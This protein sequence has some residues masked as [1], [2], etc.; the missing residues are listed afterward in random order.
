MTAPAPSASRCTA[1]NSSNSPL[2]SG[3]MEKW[4][5]EGEGRW[6]TVYANAG[7]AYAVIAG[8]RLDTSG[9]S[10]G[11]TA[12]A[13][14]PICATTSATSPVTLLA[15]RLDRRGAGTPSSLAYLLD[16]LRAVRDCLSAKSAKRSEGY[17][18]LPRS[19]SADGR[20]TREAS[21]SLTQISETA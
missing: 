14:T 15:T 9:D 10:S 21:K 18:P 2:P 17:P 11:E 16:R 13:G 19:T 3:P 6:I 5:L 7:H 1:A 8:V 20:V 12:R 4:G